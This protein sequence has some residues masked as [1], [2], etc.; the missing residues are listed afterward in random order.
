MKKT[1][2]KTL[3][4]TVLLILLAALVGLLAVMPLLASRKAPEE[5]YPY[6][7]SQD[8]DLEEYSEENT[9]ITEE[10]TDDSVT[11]RKVRPRRKKGY[12]LF[13]IP[14]LLSTVVWFAIVV[15]IGVFS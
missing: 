2:H 6:E 1:K 12:G 8:E 10:T 11:P 14:H 9:E 15:F 3:R 4:R 13:A 5:E 7:N